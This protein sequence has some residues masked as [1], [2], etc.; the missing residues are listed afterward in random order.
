MPMFYKYDLTGN[1]YPVILEFPIATSTA[2][3]EGAVVTLTEGLVVLAAANGTSA[4][5]GVAAENHTGAADIQNPRSNGKSINVYCSPTAVFGTK[6]VTV[7]TAT[8]GSSSAF[9]ATAL[10]T[11]SNDDF[12]NAKLVLKAK[13]TASTLTDPV[14]TVYDITGSTASSDSFAG[15]FPGGVSAGDKM[16][17]LPRRLFA[18]GNFTATTID[19]LDY[20]TETGTIAKVVDVDV[21]QEIIYW[22]PSLHLLG[23]KAS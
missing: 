9:A 3:K 10:G 12:K 7:L 2:I 11:Y 14:G 21:E 8:S 19:G 22:T 16:L 18:K 4:I 23:N 5:L 20:I 17:L 13:A 15:T 1:D 6:A